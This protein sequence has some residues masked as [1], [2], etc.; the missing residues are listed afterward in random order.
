MN[1]VL[2]AACLLTTV[3]TSG[4]DWPQFRGF[5]GMPAPAV[6]A[7]PLHWGRRKNLAWQA[8]LPGRG[9]SGPILVGGKVFVTCDVGEPHNRLHLLCF[10]AS[11]GQLLWDRQ[12]WPTGSTSH[13]PKTCLAAPTPA[14]DGRHIFAFY[15]T[16]DLAC[17]DLDGRLLWTRGLGYDF[18]QAHISL[19]MASSPVVADQTVV[20]QM[21]A[22][23]EAFAF[24]LDV[25]TGRTR[26]RRTRKRKANWA[27]PI[28]WQRDP[29]Q[30]PLVVLQG[31][32]GV[33]IVTARTG[34]LLAAYHADT[35]T[36]SSSVA[37]RSLLFIPS[38]GLTA[39]RFSSERVGQARPEQALKNQP[40]AQTN[41]KPQA[42]EVV[43]KQIRLRPTTASPLLHNGLLYVVTGSILKCA[44][45]A[46]GRLRWQLRLR[47]RFSSSPVAAGN[48]LYV[49]NEDGTGFVVELG[50]RGRVVAKNPLEETILDTPALTDGALFVRSDRH[51]WKIAKTNHSSA[52]RKS[53]H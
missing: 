33:E 47:G 21:E 36:I 43:W 3:L 16:N 24:G 9:V 22:D 48:H 10:Q 14:S 52:T 53:S 27:S 18:P 12:L 44:D 13:H 45:P 31:S 4:A 6:T 40:V 8:E 1:S 15:S 2:V 50:S 41:N 46:T 37:S 49:F 29:Q 23:V 19:G 28:L 38:Q 5:P 26:W 17:F 39:L 11:N 20:V 35:S 34:H 51:L 32:G 7:P 30:P 25:A 42:L